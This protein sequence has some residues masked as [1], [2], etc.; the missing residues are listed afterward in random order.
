[1]ALVIPGKEKGMFEQ[2]NIGA[3][4][5]EDKKWNHIAGK[6][7]ELIQERMQDLVDDVMDLIEDEAK[8]VFHKVE[9]EVEDDF[10]YSKFL[11]A[12]L[13][14]WPSIIDEPEDETPDY[15]EDDGEE[16]YD[17]YEEARAETSWSGWDQIEE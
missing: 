13:D 9:E 2:V 7:G 8:R 4:W 16:D 15:S 17:L 11:N 6:V 14:K 10:G 5:S 3:K 12:E 1:M